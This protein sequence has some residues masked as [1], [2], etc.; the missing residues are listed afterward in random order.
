MH[1]NGHLLSLT[2]EGK[3]IK[4]TEM[5]WSREIEKWSL[6]SEK[7]SSKKGKYSD[8]YIGFRFTWISNTE[9]PNPQCVV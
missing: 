1:Q 8:S 5:C 9:S 3:Q 2:E 7:M 6:E 4:P